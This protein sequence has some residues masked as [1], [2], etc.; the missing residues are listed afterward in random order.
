MARRIA[1]TLPDPAEPPD[2][3]RRLVGLALFAV[4]FV[5]G[6]VLDVLGTFLDVATSKTPHLAEHALVAGAIPAFAMLLVY[7]PVPLLLDRFDPEPWWSLVMA[8]LWGAFVATGCAGT[9]NTAV[10][11]LASQSMP[12]SDAMLIT[13]CVAAPITEETM[14]GLGLLGFSYFLRREF[15]GV[16]DGIVYATF[17]ALGFAAVENVHY[18]ADAAMRGRDVFQQTFVLRGLI[19]P[20]GHPLYTSMTGIGFGIARETDRPLLRVIAPPAGLLLAMSLHATWNYIPNMGPAVFA[21][22]LVLW[23][24]FVGLFAVILVV[25]VARKGRIIRENLRDEVLFGTLTQAELTR[26]TS[27][28]GRIRTYFA[29]R[30][31]LERRFLHAAARLA[32]SKWHVARAL[33]GNKRTISV[34]LIGPLREEMR[35]VRRELAAARAG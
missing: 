32:L 3:A 11:M 33:R 25:L 31:R 16:V 21:L 4:F 29:P 2:R 13:T 24:V 27:P 12:K 17:C 5:V 20:W 34:D 9:I 8:F 14:K 19:A 15:D 35:E 10:Q 30:G 26:V 18:Y 28:L 1:T 7:L 6:F 23:I 22:S